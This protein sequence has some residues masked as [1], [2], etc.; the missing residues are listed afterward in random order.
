MPVFVVFIKKSA[1]REEITLCPLEITPALQNSSKS[2]HYTA[3]F[4]ER[5]EKFAVGPRTIGL[6][7]T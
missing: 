2:S 7:A 5:I 6:H 3:N 1:Q 4:V